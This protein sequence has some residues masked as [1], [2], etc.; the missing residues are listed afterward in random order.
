[1]STALSP[2]LSEPSPVWRLG[3]LTPVR[4][5]VILALLLAF[6]FFSHLHYLIVDCPIDLS[7]DE[8]QY[9][10]WSRQLG[11]SYYSKGP[12]VAYIIRA[13][14]AL[15]GETMPAVRFPA[16]VLAVGTSLV[17]YALTAFLFRS[18]KLALG[19]VL[20]T[21]LV[22]MFVAGS[23]L[24]TIDPPYF[25]CWGVATLLVARVLF[26]SA[27]PQAAVLLWGLVGMFVGLGFLAKYAMFLWLI[28]LVV[29]MLWDA[30]S[31]RWFK[32]PG[33]WIMVGVSLLFTIPVL[34]WNAQNGWVS[35]KH[36]ATQTGNDGAGGFNP[37][38]MLEFFG[39]QVGA[40]GPG[41]A[42]LMVGACVVAWRGRKVMSALVDYTDAPDMNDAQNATRTARAI[43]FLLCIGASFFLLT[44]LTSLRAKVQV[45][46]PA[47][48]Y[49]SLMILTAWFIGNRLRSFKTWK[50]W[51]GFFWFTVGFGLVV[52]PLA[53]DMS[54]IYPYLP[55]I[56]EALNLKKPLTPRKIDPTAKI[57]GWEELG[58]RVGAELARLDSGAIVL[59][60]DYQT[61]AACAF[62]V[63]GQPV[64]YYVGS[65]F[66]DPTVR[67]RQSQ[68]DMWENRRLDQPEL[69]GRDAIYVDAGGPSPSML[70]DLRRAFDTV[71]P[72]P[73]LDIVQ[74]GQKIRSFTLWRC[75]NFRGMTYPAQSGRF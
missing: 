31:R 23:V 59:S 36:V 54:V 60:Q 63:P 1:M 35:F 17:T 19:A 9:W 12:L 43:F 32:T 26:S 39:G 75:E 27:K 61:T 24:M 72:L 67:N 18:E 56:S 5:R 45:N 6:G 22:P 37:L 53:H 14:C 38:H 33:P 28:G 42:V 29:F 44:L 51:R 10:D 21:H 16:I 66:T 20:L 40:V 47:P 3:W 25:F 15:F 2:P 8:A 71:E 4:C 65:Y 34:V 62:Y 55:K 74:R 68:Y 7:G 57:R 30:R 50:P 73:V 52:T 13:S 70:E 64:T 11:L 49:F 48:A 41:L 46:W 69:I 58:V